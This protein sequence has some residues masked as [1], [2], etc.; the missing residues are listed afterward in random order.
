MINIF[1]DITLGDS[2]FELYKYVHKIMLWAN[3]NHIIQY[4]TIDGQ[5]E[6]VDEE[7]DET[8]TALKKGDRAGII[9][10]IG[11]IFISATVR[12]LLL[13][14]THD[15]G[16]RACLDFHEYHKGCQ[17]VCK[18]S[19]L[20]STEALSTISGKSPYKDIM[21]TL[22]YVADYN[23]LSLLDCIGQ[24]YNTIKNRT[25]KMVNGVFVKDTNCKNC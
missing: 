14:N 4:G 11:D 3:N 13:D 7:I 24:A 25:G 16:I 18:W 5:K 1:K 23:K 2:R 22:C 10:G 20:S 19:Y 15:V 12:E 17:G 9:D 6:K 8:K 21:L